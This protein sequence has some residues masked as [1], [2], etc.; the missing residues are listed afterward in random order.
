[1]TICPLTV[2]GREHG[3]TAGKN[4]EELTVRINTEW[5]DAAVSQGRSG[6]FVAT[7]QQKMNI[8]HGP[9][10]V[11]SSA[12]Q[13]DERIDLA[14]VIYERGRERWGDAAVAAMVGR[15]ARF[16]AVLDRIERF[17]GADSPVL[18]TGETGTGKE[19]VARGLYLLGVRAARPFVAVNCAQYHDGPLIASEL[20]G[21]RKGSFTGAIGDHAGLFESCHRG[22]LFLDEVAELSGA[23]QAMLLRVLGEGE[24]VPVG[25]TRARRVDVRVIAASSQD[26]ATRV[27]RGLFRRDLYYRL[28]ALPIHV[29]PVRE[30]GDDWRLIREYY[31][32][33]LNAAKARRKC[34]SRTAIDV[35]SRYVWPGNVR[36]LKAI[37]DTGFYLSDDDTIEP[38]HF[39]DALEDAGRREQIDKVPMLDVDAVCYEQ[40]RAG[41][42]DFWHIVRDPFMQREMSRRQVKDILARGLAET[43]GSFKRLLP[44]FGLPDEDYL[45][46]MDF[47]RHHDLKPHH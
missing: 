28:R 22:V 13:P 40:L 9:S 16:G 19:L 20:F 44:L 7:F 39:L 8:D 32:R 23:A 14:D 33:Q 31:L 35:L 46:F 37:V 24:L 11:G 36:E 5:G 4:A 30:R 17:A 15:D 34:F 29:P 27:S 45:R 25:D 43:R 12:L 41:E 21:H 10:F 2:T 38:A 42:G 1:M 18:I 47:L 6:T 3:L 26:L